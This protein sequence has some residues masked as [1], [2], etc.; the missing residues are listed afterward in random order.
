LSSVESIVLQ[1]SALAHVQLNGARR[2]HRNAQMICGVFMRWTR[3]IAL[4]DKEQ[5]VFGLGLFLGDEGAADGHDESHDAIDPLGAL[6]L[7]SRLPAGSWATVTLAAIQRV[8]GLPPCASLRETISFSSSRV[9]A[10]IEAPESA[11][12]A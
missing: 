5:Q 4:S 11:V 8:T 6:V 7:G 3:G 1:L 12:Q 10:A 9:G 2:H